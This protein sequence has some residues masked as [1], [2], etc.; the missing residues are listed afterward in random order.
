MADGTHLS[1]PKAEIGTKT[2]VRMLSDCTWQRQW[3]FVASVV[4]DWVVHFCG[5]HDDM[6]VMWGSYNNGLQ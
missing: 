1:T 4:S 5:S 2:A 3:S 6:Y